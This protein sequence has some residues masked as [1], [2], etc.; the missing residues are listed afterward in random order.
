MFVAD[1]HSKLHDFMESIMKFYLELLI[2]IF[3]CFKKY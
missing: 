1:S 2:K 3:I